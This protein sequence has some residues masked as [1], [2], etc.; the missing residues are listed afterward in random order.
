MAEYNRS[1][2]N[3]IDTRTKFWLHET[4]YE[5]ALRAQQEY[6]KQRKNILGY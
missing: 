6:L 1:F 4:T 2:N 3:Y 5:E